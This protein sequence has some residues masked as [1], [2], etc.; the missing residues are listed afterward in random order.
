MT[1][2]AM[3]SPDLDAEQRRKAKETVKAIIVASPLIY[4][5]LKTPGELQLFVENCD[6]KELAREAM[7]HIWE[8]GYAKERG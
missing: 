8:K 1:S 4:K 5:L 6:N 7:A 3:E 2:K